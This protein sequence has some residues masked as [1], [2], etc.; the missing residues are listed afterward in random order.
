MAWLTRETAIAWSPA[1]VSFGY[2][3][4]QTTNP[5]PKD[6]TL[7]SMALGAAKQACKGFGELR[8]RSRIRRDMPRPTLSGNGAPNSPSRR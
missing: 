1:R 7:F 2:S 4:G 6:Y 3:P 5:L 8:Q